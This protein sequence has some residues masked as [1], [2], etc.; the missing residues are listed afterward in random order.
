M[1]KKE[2]W[3]FLYYLAKVIFLTFAVIF[4]ILLYTSYKYN[5]E[6]DIINI[7]KENIIWL[8]NIFLK[9]I[10]HLIPKNIFTNIIINEK[11]NEL[12]NTVSQSNIT[13]WLYSYIKN[14]K[15]SDIWIFFL[16]NIEL[17]KNI[18][19]T[20]FYSWWVILVLYNYWKINKEDNGKGKISILSLFV[21]KI[22]TW[23]II[24]IIFFMYML[25]FHVCY[26]WKFYGW[27]C[28]EEVFHIPSYIDI[29]WN[30]LLDLLYYILEYGF[31][32]IAVSIFIL[33]GLMVMFIRIYDEEKT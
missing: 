21:L 7:N 33:F 28:I 10:I 27:E 18:Y 15:Y 17:I 16:E 19:L 5:I 22:I 29:S 32:D 23:I 25:I 8:E 20:F 9:N 4:S 6:I 12:Y 3:V 31:L 24:Y 2:H 30:W 1:L 13:I 14:I 26:T 11:L